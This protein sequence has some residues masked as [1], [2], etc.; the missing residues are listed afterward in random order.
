VFELLKIGVEPDGNALERA[1]WKENAPVV[2]TLILYGAISVVY[3]RAMDILDL[4]LIRLLQASKVPMPQKIALG[5]GTVDDS[6]P[7]VHALDVKSIN[8]AV[9]DLL[10][11]MERDSFCQ[12]QIKAS[13]GH[14]RGLCLFR[15]GF[16]IRSF[17]QRWDDLRYHPSSCLSQSGRSGV[18]ALC[19]LVPTDRWGQW[20]TRP[21]PPKRNRLQLGKP[22]N[23]CTGPKVDG[24]EMSLKK[25]SSRPFLHSVQNP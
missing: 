15:H 23:E 12:S 6:D 16:K 8:T 2:S 18:C 11:R 7:F 24:F 14:E 1:I 25:I 20:M 9:Y 22:V 5:Y 21:E 13:G 19:K 17:K 10:A 3:G 4:E